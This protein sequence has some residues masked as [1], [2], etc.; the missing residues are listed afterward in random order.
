LTNSKA[1]E[2]IQTL[3]LTWGEEHRRTLPWRQTR[4]PWKVL[5]SEVMLQQTQVDRVVPKYESFVKRFPTTTACAVAPLS[6]VIEIWVGLGYNRRAVNLHRAA[7]TVEDNHAGVFPATLDGLLS[8]PGVGPY[9]ARAILAF[10]FEAD[11]APVDTN[12]GRLL[13]RWGG[14]MLAGKAAQSRAEEMLPAGRG[15]DWNQTLMD[16]GATLCRRRAPQCER[17]PVRGDCSWKGVGPD[18]ASGSAFVSGGQSRFEGSDRQGRGRLIAALVERGV[19]PR[20]EV[21]LVMGW[22]G[23]A[24]RAER[25]MRGLVADGLVEAGNVTKA[26]TNRD[27]ARDVVRLVASDHTGTENAS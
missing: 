14:E 6:A 19:V 27:I 22:P 10:A 2:R 21:P 13:A 24:E 8:L 7:A 12:I 17:C 5:V 16:F 18:P 3:V 11:A 9:T 23:D 26:N 20:A 1:E 25:V 15:W 4:D